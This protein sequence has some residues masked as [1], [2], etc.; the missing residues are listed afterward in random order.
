MSLAAVAEVPSAVSAP[1][2]GSLLS[3]SSPFYVLG[4]DCFE[5]KW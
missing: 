5:F 2:T 3:R 1:M 4:V